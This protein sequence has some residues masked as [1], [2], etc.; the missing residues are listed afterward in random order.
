MSNRFIKD[1]NSA[2]DKIR[3]EAWTEL[4]EELKRNVRYSPQDENDQFIADVTEIMK[5]E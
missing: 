1:I 2:I 5:P 4:I 3:Y